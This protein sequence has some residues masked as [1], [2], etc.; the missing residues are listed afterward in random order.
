MKN[1]K[2]TIAVIAVLVIS[3]LG[4][5]IAFA[6]FSR[7]LTINGNGTIQSSQFKIIFEGL[8]N[9]GTLDAP[10]TTGSASVTTAPTIKNDATE[11]SSFVASLRTPGDSIT[12]NFKIHNTGDYAATVSSVVMASGVNLTT[13]TEARTSAANTLNAMDYRL[14]YTDN[15]ALVGSGNAKDCLEP[16]ESENVTLRIVFSSSNETNTNV[17]PSS[18]LLLDNLGV[19]VN[20]AQANNGSCALEVGES[21]S[22]RAFQNI[23]GAY[24]TY[25]S[26]SFI[27]TGVNNII[28]AENVIG[29]GPYANNYGTDMGEGANP[30]YVFQMSGDDT[31]TAVYRA[32]HYCTGC[33]QMTYNEATSWGCPTDPMSTNIKKCIAKY[34]GSATDWWL[35]DAYNAN[36]AYNITLF[37]FSVGSDVTNTK[38]IRPVAVI[39]NTATMTGSGTSGSPYVITVAN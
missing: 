34:N 24:Y 19:T 37:G 3:V 1:R 30:R 14:Y 33:R 32:S 36:Q 28:I 11:I 10:Q 21:I 9:A 13:N 16:G 18:D 31:N 8:T 23:D 26:K 17:L 25:D 20:Y 5:G 4:L 12:Y 7:N 29:E 35:S 6:A 38:G 39:S 2:I 22:N 27:G 15:N